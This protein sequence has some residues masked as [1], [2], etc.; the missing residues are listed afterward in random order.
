M[1]DWRLHLLNRWRI[2]LLILVAVLALQ[3]GTRSTWAAWSADAVS[4]SNSFQSAPDWVAPSVTASTVALTNGKS[5]GT[6]GRNSTYYV[7]A[8]AT[9][10]GAP[11][12]GVA[13]V[14][15][16]VA[17]LTTG[18]S[19]VAL[20][21]GT[22]AVGGTS[23]GWRSDALTADP[24]LV[25]GAY[26]YPHVST[27]V[28]GNA[29]TQTDFPVN[30]D[31]KAPTATDIQAINGSGT[32]QTPDGGDVLTLTFSEP[33]DSES[34]LPGWTGTSTAVTVRFLRSGGTTAVTVHTATAQVGIGSMVFD[35]HYG[36]TNNVAKDFTG[37]TMVLSGN[38][39]T[40]TLGA[41]STPS[42]G[43]STTPIAWTVP[44]TITDLVGNTT[45]SA[46]VSETGAL[47]RD[48]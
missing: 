33:V 47:D 3:F 28:A 29:R 22:F 10:A 48:W 41:G 8:N 2:S 17:N 23:Y 39:I 18:A 19:Q 4:P 5:V 25:D 14:T 21:A 40:I 32:V 24:A 34:I 42:T 13:A 16:N 1:S 46:T 37:S 20:T 38:A 12:S 35:T 6:I 7:Y 44:A 45:A 36:L 11:A 43:N 9:D 30:V 31:A 26:T 15:T 27:D